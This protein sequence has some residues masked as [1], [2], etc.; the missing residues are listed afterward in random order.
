MRDRERDLSFDAHYN[1]LSGPSKLRHMQQCLFQYCP[2]TR[3]ETITTMPLH[4]HSLLV[5]FHMCVKPPHRYA[6]PKKAHTTTVQILPNITNLRILASFALSCF[7]SPSPSPSSVL[8]TVLLEN[9]LWQP[10]NEKDAAGRRVC[11]E[12]EVPCR[13]LDG[14]REARGTASKRTRLTKPRGTTLAMSSC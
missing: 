1:G 7:A 12:N 11:A 2:V 9:T 10:T 14:P 5:S 6:A 8:L 13:T 3:H 4:A